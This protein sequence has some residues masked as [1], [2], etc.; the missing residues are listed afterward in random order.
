MASSNLLHGPIDFVKQ[1]GPLRTISAS[2][3]PGGV[4]GRFRTLPDQVLK[5]APE[6]SARRE[7]RASVPGTEPTARRESRNLESSSPGES[8][9]IQALARAR[10]FKPSRELESSSS[11]ESSRV[12]PSRDLEI[13]RPGESSR[14]QALARQPFTFHSSLRESSRV[15]ALAKAREF[16]PSRELKSASPTELDDVW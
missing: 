15:Q 3:K 11:R 4:R 2:G 5:T 6:P 7:S 1:I 9:R 13:S 8:S 12:K 14:D 16:K 10:E